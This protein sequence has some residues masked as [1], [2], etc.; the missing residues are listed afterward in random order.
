VPPELDR[1]RISARIDA[2]HGLPK[3]RRLP[4]A[5]RWA[6]VPARR[7]YLH[8]DPREASLAANKTI[9]P[10]LVRSRAPSATRLRLLAPL[11]MAAACA[12]GVSAAVAQTITLGSSGQPA[13]EVNLDAITGATAPPGRQLAV[14]GGSLSATQRQLRIPNL[15]RPEAGAIILR[16]PGTTAAGRVRL[17]PPS[18]A[19][20]RRAAA[21]PPAPATPK[22]TRTPPTTTTTRPTPPPATATARPAPAPPPPA[23]AP[24]PRVAA[25]PP[26]ATPPRATAATPP[27]AP[28]AATT[29]GDDGPRMP[30]VPQGQLTARDVAPPPP[31]PRG[32]ARSLTPPPA[33]PPAPAATTSPP[34]SSS[35]Q[36]ARTVAPP[37]PPSSSTATTAAPR[38]EP[39]RVAALPPADD[40]TTQIRF[41]SG[42]AALAAD[43][44]QRLADIAKRLQGTDKRL[45][46]RAY[47]DDSSD[48][49]SPSRARR[50]S[51]SR[52]LA[53]RSY[54]IENGMRS[55]RIDV[56]ALGIARDGGPPDRVD[57]IL[58]ER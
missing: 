58:L 32:Q 55:T 21:Q 36:A 42:S 39:P 50:L 3:R 51:L 38:S 57:V 46:L 49:S 23:A 4:L 16:Q 40:E 44:E 45:Q 37:P 24:T 13:V 11:L 20:P 26:P 6:I 7:P 12:G 31:E 14:P 54:L 33:P 1:R 30:A 19:A 29:R 9:M 5:G 27:P 56:R 8:A 22:P 48:D 18:E 41:R 52:A 35:Q 10:A 28:P 17:R 34:A 25:A 53:V 47:A 43:D 2:Q 15:D